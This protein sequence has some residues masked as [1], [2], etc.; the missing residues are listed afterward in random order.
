MELVGY[1]IFSPERVSH[2]NHFLLGLH[3]NLKQPIDRLELTSSFHWFAVLI[4]STGSFHLFVVFVDKQGR[5][6]GLIPLRIVGL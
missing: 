6:S 5:F 4:A 1:D 3:L 2:T